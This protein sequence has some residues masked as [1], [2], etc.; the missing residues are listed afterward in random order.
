MSSFGTSATWGLAVAASLLVGALA[1]AG[2]RLPSR[3]AAALTAFGG[4]ILLAAVALELVPDADRQAGRWTTACGLLAGT[5]L[6][7]GAD[8]WLTR[9]EE[10]RT[11]R[12]AAHAAM[13]GR[14]MTTSPVQGEAARG[15][16]I[17]AGIVVDGVPES[18]A[19]GLTVTAG[20][21]GLALLAGVLVGNV[22]EAYGAAQPIIAAGRPRRFAVGLFGGIGLVLAG[23]TVLGGTVLADADPSLIGGAEALAAGAVLAVVS[24]S[25]I[26]YAFAEVSSLVAAAAVLGFIGG[27]LLS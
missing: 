1:A 20:G 13:A 5:L 3:V 25:I 19:L 9:N 4:G 7:I 6:Y 14:P 24:V 21:R 10:R 12:H 23:A 16:S 27:Y 18:I 26:P 11:I 22:V 15:E 2:L 8:A 17:A